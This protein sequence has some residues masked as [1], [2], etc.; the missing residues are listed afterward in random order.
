MVIA[1]ARQITLLNDNGI[2]KNNNDNNNDTQQW[3]TGRRWSTLFI[4]GWFE[5][6]QKTGKFVFAFGIVFAFASGSSVV[7]DVV[8]QNEVCKNRFHKLDPSNPMSVRYPIGFSV[9]PKLH[10]TMSPFLKFKSK[11]KTLS[12][13]RSVNHSR[14]WDTKWVFLGPRHCSKSVSNNQPV[15]SLVMLL[16]CIVMMVNN[17]NHD[18]GAPVFFS[19]LIC[20]YRELA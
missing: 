1:G 5:S 9:Q 16:L 11:P 6:A 13:D 14:V 4:S 10:T 8:A 15:E 20:N 19:F 3:S 2:T 12:N 17:N 18:S 7:V